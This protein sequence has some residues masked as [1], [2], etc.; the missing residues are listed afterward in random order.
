MGGERRTFEYISVHQTRSGIL[1]SHPRV[2][3]REIHIGSKPRSRFRIE[4][5]FDGMENEVESIIREG[6][7]RFCTFVN[8]LALVFH[9]FFSLRCFYLFAMP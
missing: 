3:N 8:M 4:K 9:G 6:R 2:E 7:I 5:G 1:F